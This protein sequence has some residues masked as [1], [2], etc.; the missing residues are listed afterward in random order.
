MI[1]DIIEKAKEFLSSTKESSTVK[2]ASTLV[3]IGAFI[4]VLWNVFK[5]V[6]EVITGN[7][8]MML[9]F[10]VI[11]CVI[12]NYFI[13][14]KAKTGKGKLPK[15]QLEYNY[16][17]FRA[18]FF[19]MLSPDILVALNLA[20]P[21]LPTNLDT[22]YRWTFWHDTAIY[23]YLLHTN[24]ADEEIDT[25]LIQHT[26]QLQINNWLENGKIDG[27]EASSVLVGDY[28]MPR[29]WVDEVSQTKN[30]VE[31][32]IVFVDEDYAENHRNK[33]V[34][35]FDNSLDI[36]DITDDDEEYD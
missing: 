31:V 32:S 21:K 5:T 9:L 26:F 13:K 24:N 17:M 4:L 2:K 15:S 11:L 14:P 18:K 27:K 20:R 22:T 16:K 1:H 19:K 12:G 29:I 33:A 3:I 35:E 10:I 34:V 30:M 25:E 6:T 36:R 28:A 23:G 8:Y 7:W